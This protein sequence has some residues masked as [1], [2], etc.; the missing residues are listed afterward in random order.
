MSD[1]M[2]TRQVV[3]RRRGERLIDRPYWTGRAWSTVVRYAK[4]YT[5]NEAAEQ[6]RQRFMRL[7]PLPKIVPLPITKKTAK[8][9]RYV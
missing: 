2:I 6:V 8:G 1:V 7:R 5:P 9:N 4:Q 3:I